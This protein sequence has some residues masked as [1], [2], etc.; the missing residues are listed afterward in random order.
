MKI[1]SLGHA[2][3]MIETEGALIVADPWLSPAGAFDSAWMQ[4]PQNHHLASLVRE[5]LGRTTKERF[6]Y[7]SHEHKD[8]FDPEFLST[9]EKRDVTVVVP[10]FRRDRMRRYLA[11][12]GFD[13]QVVCRDG[14]SVPL[15]GGGS[16]KLFVEDSDLNRDSSLLVRA[17]GQTF[18]NLNDCKIHDRLASLSATEGP[19]DVFT[20]QFSG[21]IWHPTCYDY[22]KPTYKRISTKKM[23]SKFEAVAR[24]IQVL[25]P[26]CYLASAGPPCFLDPALIHLN[27]EEVNIFP[28]APA[29]FQ[30]LQRRLKDSPTRL[31]DTLPGDVF[32]LD[33]VGTPASSEPFTDEGFREYVQ[34]YAERM[35]DLFAWRSRNLS[36][37][38]LQ[39][40]LDRLQAELERKLAHLSLHDR[41][42]TPLY[43]QLSDLPGQILLVDFPARRIRRVTEV[44]A[45]DRYSLEVGAANILAVLEGRLTWED[46][47]LSL[48]MRLSRVPDLYDP[49]IH[50]FLV[51]EA[52]DLEAFCETIRKN[53]ARTERIEIP[54][55]DRTYSINRFC[56]HQGADF[57]QA[58]A[59]WVEGKHLVCGRHRWQFDLE[60]GGRCNTNTSSIRAELVRDVTASNAAEANA[61]AASNAAAAAAS[62]VSATNE[63]VSSNGSDASGADS[64]D[65]E[66]G[67]EAA[68]T[69]S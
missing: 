67:D 21:A 14:D 3:F 65:R 33:A 34:S 16:L 58:G 17:D 44:P 12:A 4:F 36:A 56:P 50:G 43:V 6:L 53:E 45:T 68:P 51:V 27:F 13:R 29:F 42:A 35:K 64:D 23:F 57:S 20:A 24:A 62:E 66:R 32:D 55:G 2:G 31:L 28:R 19:I 48:R 49:L 41:V 25:A 60:A 61:F 15:A 63:A 37:D 11:E 52:E 59:C 46:F 1:T 18:L 8:H 10:R 30:F 5:K 40:V 38:S 47:M 26:R 22:D 69:A 9:L 7:L 54:V 39:G